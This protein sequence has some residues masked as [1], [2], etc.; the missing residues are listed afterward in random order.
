MILQSAWLAYARLPGTE[1]LQVQKFGKLLNLSWYLCQCGTQQFSLQ[2]F[3]ELSLINVLCT[4]SMAL[5]SDALT[6]LCYSISGE[7]HLM[8]RDQGQVSTKVA[9]HYCSPNP[10]HPTSVKRTRAHT[11]K[12]TYTHTLKILIMFAPVGGHYRGIFSSRLA[13]L[14]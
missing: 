3:C 4:S 9:C 10:E 13:V 14:A 2:W 1:Q 12:H 8:V 5:H 6:A 11:H 7:E